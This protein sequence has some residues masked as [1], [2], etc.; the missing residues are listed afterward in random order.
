MRSS[1][2][3]GFGFCLTSSFLPVL[4][5][6]YSSLYRPFRGTAID[7]TIIAMACVLVD[8]F[9]LFKGGFPDLNFFP[10]RPFVCFMPHPQVPLTLN[11]LIAQKL[12]PFRVQDNPCG[13]PFGWPFEALIYFR[14]LKQSAAATLL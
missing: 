7:F 6:L 3:F 2:F 13:I 5:L 1:T 12:S 11:N 8:L 4:F 10:P 9:R 14:A